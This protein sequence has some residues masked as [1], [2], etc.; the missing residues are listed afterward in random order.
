M[1]KLPTYQDDEVSVF[2]PLFENAL[3]SLI[4][5]NKLLF[6][7][8]ELLHHPKIKSGK[9]PDFILSNRKNKKSILIVEIKRTKSAIENF[10]FIEQVRGYADTLADSEMEKAYYILT[11]LEL[12]NFYK[13]KSKDSRTIHH[14]LEISPIV[15]GN[16]NEYIFKDFFLKLKETL[17]EILDVI[18]EETRIDWKVG[19]SALDNLLSD[20]FNDLSIWQKHNGIHLLYYFA[21]SLTARKIIKVQS[22]S[23]S[24]EHID[25]PII[26]EFNALLHNVD[27]SQNDNP[28]ISQACFEAGLSYKNGADFASVIQSIVYSNSS[29]EDK[30]TLISTDSD[31]C[32]LLNFIA[33][34]HTKEKLKEHEVITDPSA[35]SGNIL[36]ES[37]NFFDEINA[38]QIWANEINPL[39]Q[40]CLLL[41][42]SLNN[43]KSLTEK[44]FPKVTIDDI[45]NLTKKSYK[46]VKVVISNPPFRRRANYLNQE[47]I[48]SLANSVKK[49][50]NHQS[51]LD[52]GQSGVE[53]LH[54]ELM[55]SILKTNST[56]V[57][58]FP[59]RYIFSNSSDSIMLRKY[60]ISDFGLSMIIKYPHNNIFANVAKSTLI[61]C[62]NIGVKK[63]KVNFL[64]IGKNID[65]LSFNELL[66]L[67]ETNKEF[68]LISMKTVNTPELVNNLDNGWGKYFG[69]S[70]FKIINKSSMRISSLEESNEVEILPRGNAGSQGSSDLIFPDLTKSKINQIFKKIPSKWLITGIRR[71]LN[72]PLFIDSKTFEKKALSIPLNK[73]HAEE[74]SLQE[75]I[76]KMN[77]F[78]RSGG[79]QY[80]KRNPFKIILII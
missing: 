71:S 23:L 22:N 70:S 20:H 50:T 53:C 30:G 26:N 32:S 14:L 63:S 54:L 27:I 62:G 61:L 76:K 41:R 59:T 67:I 31:L 6:N 74:E 52:I 60:L 43:E 21:G 55:T 42:L 33:R 38:S 77:Q 48:K 16:F 1:S 12:I 47:E 73:T 8:Y 13:Y 49:I 46:N 80:K 68:D 19:I 57:T 29:E 36:N 79:V 35:G 28:D 11:N 17:Q 40:E 45:K 72:L 65:S 3:N 18:L 24:I 69:Q 9:I 64:N 58:V 56:Y 4:V 7:S 34:L 44:K 37:I 2:H 15:V 5:D 39:Y 51:Q 78:S 66:D 10:N 75:V 25:F